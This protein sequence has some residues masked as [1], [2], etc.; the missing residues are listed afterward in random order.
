M[1]EKGAPSKQWK[2]YM[3]AKRVHHANNANGMCR[4]ITSTAGAYP[5]EGDL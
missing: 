2:W 5:M 4:N 3:L 1:S